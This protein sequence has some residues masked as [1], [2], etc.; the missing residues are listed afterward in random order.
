MSSGWLPAGR[1]LGI[2][3]GRP[4][5]MTFC[6]VGNN[7]KVKAPQGLNPTGLATHEC[8]SC[9]EAFEIAVIGIENGLQ[10]VWVALQVVAPFF[11]RCDYCQQFLIEDLLVPLQPN[12]GPG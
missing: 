4:V 11:K 9:H 7:F 5:W 6:W 3:T 1:G 10:P 2:A 8:F 12:K